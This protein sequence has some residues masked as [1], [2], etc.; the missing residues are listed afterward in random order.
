MRHAVAA[1]L[2]ACLCLAWPGGANDDGKDEKD[3]KKPKVVRLWPGKAPDET[4]KPGP[5]TVRMSPKLDRKQVE[6][7]EQTRLVTNVSDPTITIYR[8]AKGQDVGTAVIIC[9]GG[10]YWNLFWEL[11]G[12]EVADWLA[13]LGVTGIIL[14]Y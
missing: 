11:E 9:P 5:K 3:G 2:A 10:G 8:P 7:T 4:D 12:E 14:E 6:V 1:S 13:S